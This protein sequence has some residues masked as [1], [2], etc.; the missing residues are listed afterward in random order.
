VEAIFL[1]TPNFPE[2]APESDNGLVFV[3]RLE[4]T[5]LLSDPPMIP[6]EEI[7]RVCRSLGVA[8]CHGS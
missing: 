3:W 5:D 7:G 4:F 6:I 1:D 2:D 8:S